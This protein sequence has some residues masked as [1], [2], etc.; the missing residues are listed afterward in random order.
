M[1]KQWISN[2][3]PLILLNKIDQLCLLTELSETL[4]IPKGVIDELFVHQE[5]QLPFESFFSSAK[6][7]ISKEHINIRQEIAGW[8]LGK[9]ESEV[10]SCGIKNPGYEVILD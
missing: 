3:S 1:S 9:G 2:A 10:I 4:I 6:I 5:E 7:R 8:D